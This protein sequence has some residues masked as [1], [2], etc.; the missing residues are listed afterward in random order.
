MTE[1]P[2]ERID[3]WNDLER[4]L[5]QI[6]DRCVFRG[7]ADQCWPLISSFARAF[8]HPDYE[9]IAITL[10]NQSIVTFRS[11]SHLHLSASV[12]P[13]DI[14]KLDK[15]DTYLEW[16]MLM[17]HYGAPT[18]LLDWT[19][20]PYVAV[21]FAAIDEWDR[22]AAIWYFDNQWVTEVFMQKN[23][24]KPEEYFDYVTLPAKLLHV[25]DGETVLYTALKKMR[26]A[27]EIAQQGVFTF[28][29][30][31]LTP[32]PEAIANACEGHTFGRIIIPAALKREFVH[33]LQLMNVTAASLF[34][35]VEGICQSIRESIQLR[36]ES[37]RDHLA[38]S[39]VPCE[40]PV[41][42]RS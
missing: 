18:R 3:N 27:R 36:N 29:N 25:T 17:Q 9:Q 39:E 6:A 8:P 7:Q 5:G 4:T 35:G 23:G 21:Y 13:P 20:S 1:W 16:L 32:H 19:N 15:M 37:F 31:I 2:T 22:D 40:P 38:M 42:A 24:K 10:E 12:L 41:T 33:R 14:F 11:Q 26:T 30:R 28:T 34:P